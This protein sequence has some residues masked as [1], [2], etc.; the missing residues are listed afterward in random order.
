VPE[1]NVK[2][3]RMHYLLQQLPGCIVT[4]VPVRG[5]Y[6][7]LKLPGVATSLEHLLVVV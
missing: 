4:E 1:H 3:L 6:P 2:E 7:L 5:G